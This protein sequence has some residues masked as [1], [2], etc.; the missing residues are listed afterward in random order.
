[1]SFCYVLSH[2]SKALSALLKY[3]FCTVRLCQLVMAH[4][5]KGKENAILVGRLKIGL[6]NYSEV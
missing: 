2:S 3:S 4:L 5:L 6:L 1:M